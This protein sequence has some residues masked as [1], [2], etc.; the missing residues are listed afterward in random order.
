MKTL[1]IPSNRPGCVDAFFDAWKGKGG[2]DE[3]ILL[4]DGPE[5]SFISQADRHFA[6]RDIDKIVGEANWIFSRRDSA[7]RC[8]GFLV[9]WWLG[10]DYVLTLD[11]DCFPP[12]HMLR[13]DFFSTHVAMFNAHP[14]WRS[15]VPHM[16]VRG[17]PYTDVGRL[18]NI[19]ANVGLWSGVPD[20]DARTQLETPVTDFRPPPGKWVVPRGQYV[21]ISGMN[22]CIA[23]QA[24]PLFYFP[25]MGEGQEFSRFDDIWAGIIAKKITDHL[26]WSISV[27]EPFVEHRRASDPHVN[28]QKEAPGALANETY[29]KVIDAIPLTAKD[30]IGAVAELGRG[31]ETATGLTPYLFKLGKALRVWV[32]LL[33]ERPPGL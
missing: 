12:P 8:F 33:T 30:A 1:V 28:L 11:D 14:R 9:S 27:G 5:R 15:T 23:R 24:L 18:T 26:G 6:W 19:A 3:A 13:G 10:A 2:W 29:W 17:L 31:L 25:L 4:E 32:R 16:R 22:L 21:P 7:I 20:L